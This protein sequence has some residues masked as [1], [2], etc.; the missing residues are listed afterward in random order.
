MGTLFALGF[1]TGEIIAQVRGKILPAMAIGTVLGLVFAATAGE[2]LV[3]FFIS[4][5]GL[6]IVDLTFITNP[7]LVHVIY[8]LALITA[9]Y[10]G[11]VVVTTR[12]H[13]ADKS[14]WL[15]G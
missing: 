5:A 10:L 7:L 11:T 3:G 2:S 15:R 4:L 1:S 6:G 9:G 8:P 14:S 13:R 12:L